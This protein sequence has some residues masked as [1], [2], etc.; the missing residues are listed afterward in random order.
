MIAVGAGAVWTGNREGTISRLD[1]K[2][3][4]VVATSTRTR[5]GSRPA[6][7]G[8]WVVGIDGN[9]DHGNRPTHEQDHPARPPRRLLAVRDRGR[10][11]LGVGGLGGGAAVAGRPQAAACNSDDHGRR[12]VPSTSRSATGRYGPPTSST[13]PSRASIRAPT[14]SW[15]DARRR[16]AGA[17]GRRGL[18]L[19]ERGGRERDG[20]LPALDV[21]RGL[22]R[23]AQARRPDRVRPSAAGRPTAAIIARHGRHDP[24][25]AQN[26]GYRAGRVHR[27][28][29]VVRRLDCAVGRLWSGASAPPTPMPMRARRRSSRLSARPTRLRPGGDPDPQPGAGRAAG[30]GQ[31]GECGTRTS[32]AAAGSRRPHRRP[33]RR[34]RGL[35]PHGRAQ[36]RAGDL[37]R[38]PG[39]RRIGHAGQAARAA[40]ASTCSTRL[41][42]R[43][44]SCERTLPADRRR[45]SGSGS[46]AKRKLRRHRPTPGRGRV[47]RS[48]A[49]G[50]MRAAASV[51]AESRW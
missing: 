4:E 7:K 26:H 1:P 16:V 38:G 19:G 8:V 9:D 23:R 43:R 47:A 14:R 5:D 46:R 37:A 21:Q 18:G 27:R 6:A 49:D 48:G 17:R 29:P 42:R 24:L 25:R 34:A 50:V 32:P 40:T 22:R 51:R 35:L 36:L 20:V 13:A 44:R 11:R 12:R 30:D 10:R 31:P 28:L 45:G 2:T 3:G 15:H 39:G 41:R 33:R